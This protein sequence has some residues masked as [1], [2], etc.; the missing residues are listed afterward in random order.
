MF[1]LCRKL[2]QLPSSKT[3]LVVKARFC[4]NSLPPLPLGHSS[5]IADILSLLPQI[6]RLGNV[7]TA[8]HSYPGYMFDL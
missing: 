2:S 1:P 8:I 6:S 3:T 4:L 7:W 5:S